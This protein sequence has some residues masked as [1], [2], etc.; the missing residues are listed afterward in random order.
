MQN[1]LFVHVFYKIKKED[2]L[3]QTNIF[4]AEIHKYFNK[5]QLA[6]GTLNVSCLHVMNE[7]QKMSICIFT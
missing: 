3:G 1:I 5:L 2:D 6:E 7:A 4:H